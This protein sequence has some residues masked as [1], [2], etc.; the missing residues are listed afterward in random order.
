MFKCKRCQAESRDGAKCVGCQGQF[1][2]PC[3]GITEGG[4]RKLGE[5]KNTWKCGNCKS[6]TVSSPR[7]AG[8]S[9]ATPVQADMESIMAELKALSAQMDTLPTL[10]ENMKAIQLELAELKSTRSEYESLKTG[11]EFLDQ[12]VEALAN[13]VSGLQNEVDCLAKSKDQMTALHDRC[14]RLEDIQREAEQRSRLNNLE[15]KGVPMT[16]SENL[17]EI[18]GKIGDLIGCNIPKEQINFIAR[19]P[20]RNNDQNKNIICSVHNRYLKN[21]FVAAAKKLKS[22]ITASK[23]GLKSDSVIYVND[24]LT[25]ENKMLLN[26]TKKLARERGFLYTWVVGCKI[27]T[28][29]NATSPTHHIKTEQDLKKIL[30]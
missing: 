15:I 22:S 26:K 20:T 2:F 24:H 4:W 12:T 23:L 9:T 8:T 3:A 18:V 10:M 14:S 7:P 25:F 17:F 5:R 19:V 11:V 13:K 27:L 6:S 28:R 1:D 21:N 30:N 16:N 29:K